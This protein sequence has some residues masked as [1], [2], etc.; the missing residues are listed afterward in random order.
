MD[1]E[2]RRMFSAHRLIAPWISSNDGFMVTSGSDSSISTLKNGFSTYSRPAMPPRAARRFLS[3]KN[4]CFV[5][6][7]I[8]MYALFEYIVQSS[9]IAC[10][11]IVSSVSRGYAEMRCITSRSALSTSSFLRSSIAVLPLVVFSCTVTNCSRVKDSSDGSST[12]SALEMDLR[13]CSTRF[14]RMSFTLRTSSSNRDSPAWMRWRYESMFMLCHVRSTIPGMI[15]ASR[16]L[17]CGVSS[18]RT[19]GFT[20]STTRSYSR[21][22]KESWLK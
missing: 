3:A 2:H 8:D 14:S 7:R 9:N 19:A 18:G 6:R 1:L 4:D 17:R 22:A 15:F 21:S 5:Q 11:G 13:F 12:S 16:S 20:R 10:L